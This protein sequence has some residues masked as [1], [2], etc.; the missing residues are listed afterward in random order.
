MKT[1]FQRALQQVLHHEGGWSDHP[2]DPGGATMKGVTLKTYS[3]WLGREATKDELRNIPDEHLEAL[4]R[5]DYWNAVRGDDLPGGLDLMVFDF[6]VNAGRKRAILTL[7]RAVDMP[8]AQQDGAIGPGTLAAVKE[9]CDRLGVTAVATNY[10]TLRELFYRELPTFATFGKG[11][12]RRN[13][14]VLAMARTWPAN[15]DGGSDTGKAYA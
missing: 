15:D 6:A 3:A 12:L 7:Q 9:K 1:S 11:W 5:R 10:A 4:Y 14:A 13:D 8:V 2:K